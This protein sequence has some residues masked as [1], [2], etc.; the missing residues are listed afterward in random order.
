MRLAARAGAVD[1]LEA[2]RAREVTGYSYGEGRNVDEGRRADGHAVR[3][4]PKKSEPSQ[5]PPTVAAKLKTQPDTPQGRRDA[6]LMALLL[7][8]GLRCGEVAALDIASL[9]LAAGLLTFYRAKVAKTQTHRLTPDTARAAVR[10]LEHDACAAGPLLRGSRKSGNLGEPG[11]SERAITRRVAT[12]GRAYGLARLSAHDCRHFWATEA[13]RNG[14]PIDRLQ[15]AGGWSSPYM[16]LAYVDR[17]KIANEGVRL[18]A[19]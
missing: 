13:A 15:D 19:E 9:D 18:R 7:D 4:G 12:L 14:T 17:A 16:P 2:T 10:Y 3:V 6:L 5:I 11:M 1:P 8:H